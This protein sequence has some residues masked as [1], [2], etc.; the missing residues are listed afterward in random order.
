MELDVTGKRLERELDVES[1]AALIAMSQK[2]DGEIPWCNG[3]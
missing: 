2:K 3:Q 1:T